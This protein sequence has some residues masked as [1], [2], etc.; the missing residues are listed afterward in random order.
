[1]IIGQV[2]MSPEETLTTYYG[3]WVTAEGNLAVVACEVI[4]TENVESFS[5]TVQTKN[6]EESD[7][8]AVA[9]QGGA[10]NAITPATETVTKFNVGAKLSSTTD[11]GFK[12]L[13]RYK[14]KVTAA[15]GTGANG[16]VHF[17]MMNPAWL[18]H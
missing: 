11:L 3:P 6:S 12:E 2:L 16:F 7:K 10:D 4:N 5:V 17:R 9:P 18:T 1:M 15:S 8:D 13:M 14:F